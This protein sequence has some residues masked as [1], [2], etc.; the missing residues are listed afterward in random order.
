MR[1]C[2]FYSRSVGLRANESVNE[3]VMRSSSSSM[4]DESSIY[5]YGGDV[6]HCTSS[7][8]RAVCLL[9]VPYRIFLINQVVLK[10]IAA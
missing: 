4:L 7:V 10:S 9:T 8:L 3:N 5:M 6:T 2:M 1:E